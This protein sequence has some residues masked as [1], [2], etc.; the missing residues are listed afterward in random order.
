MVFL[1]SNIPMY[2]IGAPH[3]NQMVAAGILQRLLTSGRKLV[4]DAEVFQEIL[5]RYISINRP[6][7]IQP[8][9]T[10]LSGLCEEVFPIEL[11]DVENAKN[12][13]LAYPALSSRDAIHAALMTRNGITEIVSF[14]KGFDVLPNLTRIDSI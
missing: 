4:T 3:S 2:L 7:A 11:S 1:D 12:L 14:D 10:T 9:F 8:A 6:H 13:V 5:H